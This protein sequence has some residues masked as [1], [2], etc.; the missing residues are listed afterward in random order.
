MQATFFFPHTLSTPTIKVWGFQT[1]LCTLPIIPKLTQVQPPPH[2]LAWEEW[3]GWGVK[4]REKE[5]DGEKEGEG[6]REGAR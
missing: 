4:E 2:P 1:F 6:G 5:L 3:G